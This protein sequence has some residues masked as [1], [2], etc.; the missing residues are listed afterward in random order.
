MYRQS[1]VGPVDP[2]F[3]ALSGRLKF[4]ARRH[5]F[6]KDP[7]SLGAAAGVDSVMSYIR[8]GG[9]FAFTSR[10]AYFEDPQAGFG[11]RCP[12]SHWNLVRFEPLEAS[13]RG[14]HATSI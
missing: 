8:E 11:A 7:F 12:L 3:R 14:L 2:S 9:L 6:N 1:P 4:T 10:V 5:K 13:A